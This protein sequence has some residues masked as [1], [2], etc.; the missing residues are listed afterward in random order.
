MIGQKITNEIAQ[1][2]RSVNINSVTKDD[3]KGW[4]AGDNLL[5]SGKILT[6]RDAAHRKIQKLIADGKDLPK[7]LD[8]KNRFIYY[9][10]PVPKVG[11]EIIGPAGPTT[12]TRMDK[13]TDMML[14]QLSLIGMIGK[15]ERGDQAI[16]V[17]K[18]HRGIYLIAIGGAA[19]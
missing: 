11:N 2:S 18:Q 8:F 10:G 5:L 19:F 17:I 15:A 9:V 3:I 14:G 4:K 12:A 6:G 13:F 16:E 7:G 1:G